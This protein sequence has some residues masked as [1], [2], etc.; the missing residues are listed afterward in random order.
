MIT[1]LWGR[2][3]SAPGLLIKAVSTLRRFFLFEDMRIGATKNLTVDWLKIESILSMAS[4]PDGTGLLR[5]LKEAEKAKGLPLEGAAALL[6]IEDPVL[7]ELVYKKARE[8][9]ERLFGKRVVLF[10]PLYLSNHCING[11]LYCGFRSENRTLPRK[12]LKEVELVREAST[13]EKMGFKRLLLVVGED[14]RFGVDYILRAVKAIYEKTGIRIVH[15]NAPPMEIEDLKRL[16]DCDVGVYQVFQETYHRPTYE[17][18][19]PGG[20]KSDYHRRLEVMDRALTAGFSDVGIGA[21]LGLYDYR[22]DVL[23]TI[24]HSKHL[25]E[26]FGA[27]AHTISV[28]RLRPAEGSTLKGSPWPVTDRQMKKIAAV[29]RLAVPSAGLVVSTRESPVLRTELLHTG[30]SQLSAASR[31][32]PGGYSLENRNTPEQFSTDDTRPLGE[33]MASIV[34][35]GYLPSLCT[36]CYRVGRVGM[37]FTEI[38]TAGEMNKF[39]QAN[40][41]ITLK[42]YILD[43]AKNGY[44]GLFKRALARAFEEIK[45]PAIS[46]G[47]QKR[48]K[49]LEEGKRDLF[50]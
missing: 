23:A 42:E 43:H 29:Y 3:F 14:P 46:K 20:P 30:A 31:T 16:K 21:L 11:C 18:M 2:P 13:L 12:A 32:D 26:S 17:K 41:L 8:V 47:L 44:N 27:H 39:C 37:N 36:T 40:A 34:S 35:E 5:I 38:T 10:A 4:V 6:T 9:K 28:P 22:F 33:V 7:L 25:C 45:D 48:L 50:F 15:V 19:H 49:E 24:A 1:N